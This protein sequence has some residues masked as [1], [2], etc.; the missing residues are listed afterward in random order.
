[1]FTRRTLL[2]TKF[3]YEKIWTK[4]CRETV[5]KVF[6]RILYEASC[7]VNDRNLLNLNAE[8]AENDI[9]RESLQW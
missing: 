3:Y 4:F 7:F 9:Q 5:S 1:M 6:T 8:S 2:H